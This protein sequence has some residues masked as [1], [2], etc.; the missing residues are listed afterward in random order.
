VKKVANVVVA[1]I[2]VMIAVVESPN[3]SS[4]V[5]RPN[6]SFLHTGRKRRN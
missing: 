4:V 2:I 3:P 6:S 5:E 1:V